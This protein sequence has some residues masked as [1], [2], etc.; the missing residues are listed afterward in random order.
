MK[1]VEVSQ[2]VRDVLQHALCSGNKLE[3]VGQL[4][5][6]VYAAVN[7]VLEALGGKWN[8]SAKA[9]VFPS[10]A[11]AVI[12]PL[13]SGDGAQRIEKVVDEKKTYNVFETPEPVIERM[14]SASSVYLCKSKARVLE[15]SAGSGR[16]VQML[17]E[18]RPGYH[19][20]AVELRSCAV[21]G[22]PDELIEGD[23]LSVGPDEIG[24]PVD[25]ILANPPFSNGQDIRHLVHM[26]RFAHPI[27]TQGAT[28]IICI[29]SPGWQFRDT[30]PYK[31]FREWFE[32]R[33]DRGLASVTKLEEGTFTEE[34]TEIS[35]LM[36]ALAEVNLEDYYDLA[37]KI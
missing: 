25:L 3:L 15:P 14:L 13:I 11:A 20:S 23:F 4:D 18:Y 35:T 17:R 5:R 34:G 30:R 2:L 8:R 6:E 24:G 27:D 21:A 10:D 12:A 32:D 28:E 37:R 16:I 26:M 31:Q 1:T 9:H 7:K 29:T 33:R 22:N 36:V 19:I